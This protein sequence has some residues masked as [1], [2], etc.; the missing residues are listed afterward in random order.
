MTDH[1]GAPHVQ[2]LLYAFGADTQYE[3][4]LVGAL[5]R[6]ESGGALAAAQTLPAS[7]ATG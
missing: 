4:R 2:L 3:G 7:P 6:V 5:E 1:L